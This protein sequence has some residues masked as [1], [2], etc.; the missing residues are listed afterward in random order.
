MIFQPLIASP[1][2]QPGWTRPFSQACPF[3]VSALVGPACPQ[4]DTSGPISPRRALQTSSRRGPVVR[5]TFMMPAAARGCSERDPRRTERRICCTSHIGWCWRNLGQTAR[6]R[7]WTHSALRVR[8]RPR[9]LRKVPLQAKDWEQEAPEPAGSTV[10]LS[11]MESSVLLH[12]PAPA[13]A[14]V[15]ALSMRNSPCL[16]RLLPCKRTVGSA[17]TPYLHPSS[18]PSVLLHLIPSCPIPSIQSHPCRA[19]SMP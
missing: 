2:R 16:P 18:G 10:L 17:F 4:L 3:F 19:A 13:P 9:R 7:A 8:S 5:S 1:H 14:P 15:Q 6:A 12:A 11:H